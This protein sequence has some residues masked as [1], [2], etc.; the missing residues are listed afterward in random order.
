MTVDL[1]DFDAVAE[2]S[3][4]S[5][6]CSVRLVLDALP[7]DKADALRSAMEGQYTHVVIAKTV[8][9]WGHKMTNYTISR[10]RKHECNCG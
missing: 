6:K 5:N 2:V 7:P 8:A 9:G 4:H 10:H 1:S 3:G